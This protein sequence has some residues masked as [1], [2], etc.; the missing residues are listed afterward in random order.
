MNLERKMVVALLLVA[1]FLSVSGQFYAAPV[2][3]QIVM[4]ESQELA[5][6]PLWDRDL[7]RIHDDLDSRLSQ[8]RIGQRVSVV[9]VGSSIDALEGMA[10]E[11]GCRITS[12]YPAIN[13]VVMEMMTEQVFVISE[14]PRI[15]HLEDA[16]LEMFALLDSSLVATQVPEAY[17]AYPYHGEGMVIAIVDTGIDNAHMDLDDTDPYN[18]YKVIA[19]RDIINDRNDY[20]VPI[21]AYDDHGHGTH[22]ASIAAGTGEASNGQYRGVA[23]AA[24]LVG[25]K[26]LNSQGSGSEQQILDGMQWVIDNKDVYGI[27]V[28][29]MSLGSNS[30]TA[31]DGTDALCQMADAVM[32]A[33]LLLFVAAGNHGSPEWLYGYNKICSPAASKKAVTVGSVNDDGTWS[34]FSNEGPT[35][36]NRI[37]PDVMAVGAAVTAAKAG[38]TNQYVQYSGTSMATPTAAGIGALLRQANPDMSPAQIKQVLESSALDKGTVGKD[39]T[40]GSGIIQ[41]KAALDEITGGADNPPTVAINYPASGSTVSGVCR[42]LVSASDD[43]SLASVEIAVDGVFVDVTSNYD[44][45]NYYYDWDTTTVADGS[46]TL[47]ARAT[48]SIDQTATDERS[49]VVNNQQPTDNPPTCSIVAPSQGATVSG[50]VRIQVSASDDHG[51]TLVEVRIDGGSWIDITANIDGAYYY[52]DWDTTAMADGGHTIEAR[53]HDT[54][55][56]TA[57]ASVSVTVENAPAPPAMFIADIK[58]Y[59]FTFWL[60]AYCQVE[61]TVVSGTPSSYTALADATVYLSA[62]SP[63]NKV[64]TYTA[65]TSST[66]VALFDLGFVSRGHWVFKVTNLSH[67]AYTYDPSMNLSGDTRE[68]DL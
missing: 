63:S 47:T 25:V 3:T 21:A 31:S 39:N 18:T 27:D 41:T 64:T 23:Y 12:R 56:Q 58:V 67:S 10:A 32:D 36:D 28:V 57:S 68:V 4:Y 65:T 61:V 11:Y 2:H 7:N 50:T 54:V 29:S 1:A 55:A 6:S 34:S 40:Y 43:T 14:D 9:V 37:K 44:G 26:V 16:S 33:G 20:T 17:A 13:S 8:M 24:Q 15:H 22:C 38:T 48:D 30:A 49:V 59:S 60:W 53:A 66:G 5:Y 19:F 46:H 35:L 52:Y 45:S 62:T 51:V 42:V